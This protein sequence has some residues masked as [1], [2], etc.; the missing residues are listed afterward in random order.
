MQWWRSQSPRRRRRWVAAAVV[1]A[2]GGCGLYRTDQCRE[3]RVRVATGDTYDIRAEA[4]VAYNRWCLWPWEP[5]DSNV[6]Y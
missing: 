4:L 2:L 6:P 3:A 5:I 1:L